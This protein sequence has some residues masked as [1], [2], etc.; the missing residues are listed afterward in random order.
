[1]TVLDFRV[2]GEKFSEEYKD[3]VGFLIKRT[4]TD[5]TAFI[6]ENPTSTSNTNF[7]NNKNSNNN[8][9][10]NNVESE[11]LATYTELGDIVV[12]INHTNH[13][14]L[15]FFLFLLFLLLF[16]IYYFSS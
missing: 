5:S 13:G 4:E 9:N 12:Y 16:V 8:N 1:M 7:N 3:K 14:Y 6:E 2:K 10:N 15:L 11:C